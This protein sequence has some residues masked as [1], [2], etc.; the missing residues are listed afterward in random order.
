MSELIAS[1]RTADRLLFLLKTHGALTTSELAQLLRITVPAVRGH[2]NRLGT[3]GLVTTEL[4][5]AGVGRP[6]QSWSL[7]GSAH[8]RFPDTHAETLV[9]VLDALRETLGDAALQ[10][11]I[12]ARSRET[13]AEYRRHMAPCRS[14]PERLDALARLRSRDGYMADVQETDGGW[15]LAEQHCPICA[16]ARTCQRFC[17]NELEMFRRLLGD[18]AVVERCEYLLTGARRCAYRVTGR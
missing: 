14:L 12:D 2:L 1:D 9:G 5:R 16:A 7:S 17:Q 3:E 11:V 4:V 8:A 6:A 18:E 15:V 10:Q 13:E